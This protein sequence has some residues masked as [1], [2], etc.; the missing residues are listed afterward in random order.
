MWESV[1]LASRWKITESFG[2]GDNLTKR[3]FY[4]KLLSPLPNVA[5][6]DN[7]V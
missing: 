3:S 1:T 2:K 5:K 6:G 7:F 4:A